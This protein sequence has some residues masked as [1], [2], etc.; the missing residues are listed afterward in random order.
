MTVVRMTVGILAACDGV[1]LG[2]IYWLAGVQ[3][4]PIVLLLIISIQISQFNPIISI[5]N[6]IEEK[7]D[8]VVTNDD[9]TNT[10]E[11]IINIRKRLSTFVSLSV[12]HKE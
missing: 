1:T 11:E 4:L 7:T 12:H 6:Q 8:I 3:R 9:D 10:E 2:C 5:E